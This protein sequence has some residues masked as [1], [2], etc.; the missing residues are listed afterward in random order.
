MA[1]FLQ[2]GFDS[3]AV[4]GPHV[5]VQKATSFMLTPLARLCGYKSYYKEY[6]VQVT[7]K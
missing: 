2:A 4:D 1:M 3:Y 7:N 5:F 6:D